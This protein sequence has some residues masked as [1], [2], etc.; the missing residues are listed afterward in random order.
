MSDKNKEVKVVVEVPYNTMSDIYDQFMDVFRSEHD[1]L[2]TYIPE[3]R[4]QVERLDV[5]TEDD[6]P[7]PGY[8]IL[9]PHIMGSMGE[10]L[11]AINHTRTREKV[12]DL[13]GQMRDAEINGRRT[14]DPN[15]VNVC[16]DVAGMVPPSKSTASS[17]LL[18]NWTV[19]PDEHPARYMYSVVEQ[20]DWLR[21]HIDPDRYDEVIAGIEA[22]KRVLVECE[23]DSTN[24]V[25]DS[26]RIS[27]HVEEKAA[28]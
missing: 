26:I 4:R 14:E 3:I 12:S 23:I 5:H 9:P 1:E 11:E 17:I 24:K 13:A 18:T 25:L 19:N 27:E 15:L 21:I 16:G 28:A 22:G 6:P 10:L 20:F 8:I 7:P 2:W